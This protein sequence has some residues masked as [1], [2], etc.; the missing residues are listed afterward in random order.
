V[1]N[2]R[3]LYDLHSCGAAPSTNRR[4]RRYS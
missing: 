4:F 1:S 3:V 2:P